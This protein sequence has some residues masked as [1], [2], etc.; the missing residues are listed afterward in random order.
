MLRRLLT[1]GLV[2]ALSMW[3]A[4][5]ATTFW[6]LE[7][8]DVAVLE[9]RTPEGSRRTTRVWYVVDDR[10][11]LRVEAGA[12]TS[13]WLEDVRR[14]PRLRL[15]IDGQAAAYEAAIQP[16]PEGHRDI[17]KRLRARYGARDVWIAWLFDTSTSF[18][19]ELLPAR[20]MSGLDSP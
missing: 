1:T 17:R 20:G 15:E 18:E 9:T 8:S 5:A 13:P 7:W 14:D 4:V 10:G 12:E 3:G 11:K 2:L 16:N 6:A 19:V